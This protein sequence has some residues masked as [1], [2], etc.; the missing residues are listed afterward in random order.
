MVNLT[1]N[2]NVKSTILEGKCI[3]DLICYKPGN[4]GSYPPSN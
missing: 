1:K 4:K 2:A 3:E